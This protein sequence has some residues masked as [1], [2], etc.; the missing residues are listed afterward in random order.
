LSG[1]DWRGLVE[2]FGRKSRARHY[3]L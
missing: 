1:L 2:R 3:R